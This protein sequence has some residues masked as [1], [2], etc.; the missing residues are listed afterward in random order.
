MCVYVSLCVYGPCYRFMWT[1]KKKNPFERAQAGI[2]RY[3]E[4]LL[5]KT[6]KQSENPTT[7]RG[8]WGMR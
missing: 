6:N 3:Q 5:S 2:K 4:T 8:T 7:T 1:G